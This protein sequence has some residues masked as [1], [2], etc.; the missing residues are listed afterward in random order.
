MTNPDWI[1]TFLP[2]TSV[3]RDCRDCAALYAEVDGRI[4]DF[5]AG[6]GVTCPAG[7][8]TCCASFDPPVAWVEAE[9]VAMFLLASGRV[10]P[11]APGA[12]CPLFDPVSPYHCTVY[13][14]RPLICRTFGFTGSTDANGRLRFAYCRHMPHAAPR[15]LRGAALRRAFTVVPPVADVY[16]R[17]ILARSGQSEEEELTLSRAL[18]PSM[19]KIAELRLLVGEEKKGGRGVPG[20]GSER[21]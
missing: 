14:V 13:A 17:R 1:E 21:A 16:A 5:A 12:A 20:P 11:P 8:G 15:T 18:T 4:A 6:S 7:C 19:A 2:G 10:A 3:A 9:L